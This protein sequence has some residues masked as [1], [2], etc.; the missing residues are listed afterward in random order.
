MVVSANKKVKAKRGGNLC[1][2]V[3]K[4]DI[5]ECGYINDLKDDDIP[6]TLQEYKEIV[7]KYNRG[8]NGID[9]HCSDVGLD[10]PS[11]T[12]KDAFIEI[13]QT[14]PPTWKKIDQSIPTSYE[15]WIKS[16]QV[17]RNMKWEKNVLSGKAADT[18]APPDFDEFTLFHNGAE[19]YAVAHTS[20]VSENIQYASDLTEQEDMFMPC[21]VGAMESQFLKMQ[22]QI[23]GA[24]RCL[25]IG[26][27]TGMSAL[28]MA[29]GI[30]KD[31]RV[32]TLEFYQDV[33][34]V[35][36]KVF[37]ASTVGDKI[38]LKVG[39]ASDYMKQMIVDKE[40]FDVIFIDADKENYIEYYELSLQLLED[41][42][43]IM[44]DNSLCAL[45]YDQGSDVRS[46]K[47]HEFNQHVK[48]DSRTEQVV[49][50]VREGVTL[51]RRVAQ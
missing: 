43:I 29:E 35:A 10:D 13:G 46:L 22:C 1:A 12:A 34:N 51:I 21:M 26:T 27:F 18:S 48:N 3:P 4:R 31:G 30:P 32:V 42:G 41:G 47:L 40:K 33:A 20:V 9:M 39:K 37:D 38:D 19:A 16:Q 50:T 17:K 44:A 49:L 36:Q 28:A 15:D 11:V 25:D 23:K 6:T 24:R 8:G 14:P 45:L 2:P 7:S 5:G